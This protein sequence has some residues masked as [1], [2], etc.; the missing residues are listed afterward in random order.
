M[1]RL[2][3]FV[4]LCI[5]SLGTQAGV[6]VD[7]VRMWP[8]PD[9]TRVV[10]DLA[11]PVEHS[12][13]VLDNPA[14]VVIDLRNAQLQNKI[15]RPSRSDKLLSRVRSA[16]RNERDLRVVLDL[17][18]P[19]RPRSFLLKPNR[20]YG[21]RL[22]V[23]LHQREKVAAPTKVA[24]RTP[25][26]ALGMRDVV[27]A[28]DAGHGGD[29]PGASG[30]A[31]TRE[32]DVVL[33]VAKELQTLIRAE[34]GMKPVLVRDGD[35]YIGLRRRMEIA[36][37]HRADLFISIHADSFGDSR[38][39]GSAVYVLS[40]NGASSEAARWLAEQENAADLAG[41]VSLDDKDELLASVLLDLSQTATMS[42]STELGSKV[43]NQLSRVGKVHKRHVERAGFMVLKSPDVPSILVESAFIS[44]PNEERRLKNPRHRRKLARAIFEGVRHYFYSN[45]PPDTLL[46]A[47]RH[48]IARGDT[49]SEIAARYGV[50]L[51]SLREVNKLSDNDIRIGKVLEIPRQ[52]GS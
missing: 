37:A 39:S 17:K 34:R 19:V 21:H 44:N 24:L 46:A 30:P 48:V 14:R 38:V 20:S 9:H 23:D 29:D 22:V 13:F 1:F 11:G 36:R 3:S 31:G 42:A 26:S 47:T 8:A 2:A 12:V 41:G 15:R 28:I 4:L 7:N 33:A 10:F 45:A 52:R 18:G 50:S 32:K 40:R 43:L 6:A 5:V 25:E 16:T 49:L 51:A 27:V 35:Y